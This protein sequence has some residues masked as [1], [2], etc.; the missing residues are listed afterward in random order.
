MAERV[1]L[2]RIAG[3]HGVRGE[4]RLASFTERPE[5]IAEYG[6]LSDKSGRR[7]F[8]IVLKGRVRGNNLV[9][10]IAGIADRNAAE[11]LAGT[12]LY[13][14]RAQLPPAGDE[15]E[16]YHVDLIGLGVEDEN[17]RALGRVMNVADYGA[18]PMLEI[19]DAAGRELLLAFTDAVVPIVDVAGG[20]LVAVPPEEIEVRPDRAD[21]EA[22]GEAAGDEEAGGEPAETVDGR[23]KGRR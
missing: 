16:Y 14:D 9:A 17:G 6:P 15:G 4:V 22:E 8:A 13:V 21:G 10:A 5:A 19:R 3:A 7:R 12:E 20:R 11:A 18:G 23:R 1:L 2:G